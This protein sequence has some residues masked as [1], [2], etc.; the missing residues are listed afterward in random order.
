M[1]LYY[2]SSL[3]L[4]AILEESRDFDLAAAW[5][6][7]PIRL[8]SNLLQIECIIGI[9]RAGGILNL[10]P[11]DDWI[12]CRIELLDRYFDGI[13]FKITDSSIEKIIR[14]NSAIAHCRSLDAIHLA[15]ALYFKPNLD[16]P[17]HIGTLDQRLRKSAR[18][19][20]FELFPESDQPRIS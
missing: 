9:R 6:N 7:V 11:D 8:S 18:D 14:H 19:L 5:D 15:T 2:D 3:I 4:S 13:H 20:G 12:G 17:L 1:A 16:E 10:R